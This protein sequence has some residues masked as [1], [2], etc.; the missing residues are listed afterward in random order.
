MIF[1]HIIQH[2]VMVLFKHVILLVLKLFVKAT[3][4]PQ[5]TMEQ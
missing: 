5:P 4:L 1:I 3:Y 2:F